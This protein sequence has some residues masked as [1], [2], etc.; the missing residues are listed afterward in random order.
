MTA[1]LMPLALQRTA[2]AL[3]QAIKL[4]DLD[5]RLALSDFLEEH[6]IPRINGYA[7]SE[8]V[9]Q[10]IEQLRRPLPDKPEPFDVLGDEGDH[11]VGGVDVRFIW[12]GSYAQCT[13]YG[14]G[15]RVWLGSYELAAWVQD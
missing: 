6:G 9:A 1:A 3:I 2:A 5:A 15:H 14:P 11:D 8:T 13:Y 12:G 7:T 10:T 4:G